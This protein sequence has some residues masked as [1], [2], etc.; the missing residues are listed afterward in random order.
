MFRQELKL[1][2]LVQSLPELVLA[3]TV[4]GPPS[5]HLMECLPDLSKQFVLLRELLEVRE[6]ALQLVNLRF[7]CS[8]LC[9]SARNFW[10]SYLADHSQ[11][12]PVTFQETARKPSSARQS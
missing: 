9:P 4:A 5:H 2:E 8:I 6:V 12:R 3:Q 10:I 1:L 11:V 7:G